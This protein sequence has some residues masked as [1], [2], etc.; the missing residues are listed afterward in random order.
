MKLSE[1]RFFK[2]TVIN[3]SLSPVKPSEPVYSGTLSGANSS[4]RA[5]TKSIVERS[6]TGSYDEVRTDSE[7]NNWSP[8]SF[9]QWF[10]KENK[11]SKLP[12]SDNM[13]VMKYEDYY[14]EDNDEQMYP[15]KTD[16]A[17]KLNGKKLERG[18]VQKRIDD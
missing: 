12:G 18:S 14:N 13:E 2:P 10:A 11:D 9:M 6:K 3:L 17:S 15:E 1:N 4:N 5:V 16:P 8:L 7:T